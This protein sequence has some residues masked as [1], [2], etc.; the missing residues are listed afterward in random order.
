M[1]SV[2]SSKNLSIYSDQVRGHPE[3]SKT[4]ELIEGSSNYVAY[5]INR[6]DFDASLNQEQKDLQKMINCE[7]QQRGGF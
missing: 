1:D 6:Q 7:K 5:M 3:A 4:G 2:C